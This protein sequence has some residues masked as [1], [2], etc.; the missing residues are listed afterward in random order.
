MTRSD[1]DDDDE[2]LKEED[3]FWE[4]ALDHNKYESRGRQV[5]CFDH[6]DTVPLQGKITKYQLPNSSVSLELAPIATEDGIWAPVGADAWYASALLTV[7]IMR[8]VSLR[9]EDTDEDADR[10]FSRRIVA[11]SSNRN[12]NNIRVLELGSGAVGLSGI[13]FAAALAQQETRFPCWTVT[14]TDNDK[15]LLKQLEKN[16]LSNMSNIIPS[17]DVVIGSELAYTEETANALVK[18]ILKLLLR[19][20][21]VQILIVQV[22]D[23]YGWSE[24]VIPVLE[25]QKKNHIKIEKIPLTCDVHEQASKMIQMGGVGGVGDRFAFGAVCISNAR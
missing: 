5:Y 10:I 9:K 23:R 6:D 24:I 22:T 17:S 3:P 14:L 15:T 11:T 19:N 2:R 25:S 4:I 13:A 16:V 8:E 18:I 7:L 1:V 20:P 12:S 21:N